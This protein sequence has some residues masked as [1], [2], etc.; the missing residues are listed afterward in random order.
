MARDDIVAFCE[1]WGVAAFALFGSVLRPDFRDDGD[2]DVLLTF[3]DGVRYTLFDLVRMSDEL[4]T[5]F[6]RTVD[7]L[8]RK[9]VEQSPNYLRRDTILNAAQ[10]IYAE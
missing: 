10:V 6:G 5:V 4:E 2:I 1:R 7:V 8:D 3:R 9:A